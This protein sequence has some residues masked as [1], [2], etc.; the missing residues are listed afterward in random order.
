MSD[1]DLDLA[2]L[3]LRLV[4]GLSLAAHG[5][6]KVFGWWDGPGLAG[7]TGWL[8]SMGVRGPRIASTLGALSEL[9]GGLLFAAGLLTPLAAL[10]IVSVMG[11][12]IAY[13]HLKAGYWL[14][15]NG[16]EYNLAI[17]AVAVAVAISGPGEWSVD[18]ALD[19]AADTSGWAWG[20]GALVLGLF[21]AAVNAASRQA[22]PPAV[23]AEADLPT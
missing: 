13:V 7:F 9:V 8:A 2:L 6:Q 3:I 20:L 23:P 5:A 12:A 1:H 4:F 18:D 19:I 17:I 15:G 21:A 16:Y 14:T 10:L 22:P 11:T